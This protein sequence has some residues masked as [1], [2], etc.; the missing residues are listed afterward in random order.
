VLN[1]PN[2][3][4]GNRNN[5]LTPIANSTI[6]SRSKG[7]VDILLQ[8]Y[9]H[10]IDSKYTGWFAKRFY[11]IGDAGV[12]RAASEAISDT[13]GDPKRLFSFIIKKRSK[14]YAGNQ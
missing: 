2:S 12:R 14:G 13:K 6:G 1:K 10:L 4:I 5:S 8:D 3:T 11:Y 7:E 9:S